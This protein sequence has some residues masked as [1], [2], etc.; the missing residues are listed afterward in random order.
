MSGRAPFASVWQ[1]G[2]RRDEERVGKLLIWL[3]RYFSRVLNWRGRW[4]DQGKGEETAHFTK[5]NIS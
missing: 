1:E 5:R 2:V 3:S 4:M